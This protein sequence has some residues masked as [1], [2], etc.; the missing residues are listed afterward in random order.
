[1][2]TPEESFTLIASSAQEKVQ[3][4]VWLTHLIIPTLI[5]SS[6]QEKVQLSV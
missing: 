2:T 5:A 1:V 3:L 4:S 6:A